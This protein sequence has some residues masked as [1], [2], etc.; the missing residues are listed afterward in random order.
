MV[1]DESDDDFDSNVNLKTKEQ[2]F[3]T[4]Q[5]YSEKETR[6]RRPRV[7]Q[8]RFYNMPK[9]G[10]T[11]GTESSLVFARHWDW[12]VTADGHRASF[13]SVMVIVTTEY[14]QNR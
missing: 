10:R 4:L 7:V 11:V 9:I 3:A 12:E 2:L 1:H 5:I 6:H 14:T 8:F 13:W